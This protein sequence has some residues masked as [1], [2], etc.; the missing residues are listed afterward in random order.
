MLR[1]GVCVGSELHDTI[2]GLWTL[3]ACQ[4]LTKAFNAICKAHLPCSRKYSV[5]SKIC[6]NNK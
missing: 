4:H 1:G 5:G 3:A 6:I 2:T